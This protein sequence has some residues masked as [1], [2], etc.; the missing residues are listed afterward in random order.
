VKDLKRIFGDRVSDIVTIDFIYPAIDKIQGKMPKIGK[1]L[2]RF[3]DWA[4]KNRFL[5][6]FGISIFAIVKKHEN[7]T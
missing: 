3:C 6:R 2:R 7:A 5:K 1:T 4:E